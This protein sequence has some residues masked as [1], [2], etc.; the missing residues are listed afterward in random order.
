MTIVTQTP[1]INRAITSPT[2]T[3]NN[4]VMIINL[5]LSIKGQNLQRK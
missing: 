2:L 3:K 4:W 1:T 5:L